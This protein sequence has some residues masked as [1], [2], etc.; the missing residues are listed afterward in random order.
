LGWFDDLP[1]NWRINISDNGWTTDQ[2]G[3]EW[4]KT[5]FISN[6][7]SR[8][9][10]KYRMLILDGYGSHLTAEF[11]HICTENNI[12]LVCMPLYSLHL[13]QPLDVGCFA[14][15]KRYYGQHVE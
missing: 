9:R 12:I 15:L 13:L 14:V 1:S 4:L 11:D 5:H 6:I 8:T 7:N 3:L 2:I 10:G